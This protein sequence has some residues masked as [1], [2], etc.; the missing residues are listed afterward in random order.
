MTSAVIDEA[1]G[2]AD[3]IARKI[4][5]FFDTVND[6]L[7]WVP[8][9][10]DHLIDP[11]TES[12][13]LLRQKVE[14]FWARAEDF[15]TNRGD[16]EKLKQFADE[17]S[18]SIGNRIGEIAGDIE[19]HRLRTNVVWEGRAADAY[20]AI[21]PPQSE[22]LEGIKSL[23]NQISTSLKS[24]AN[25]IEDF[26]TAI[27]IAFGAFALAIAA[28]IV[29]AVTVVGIPAAIAAVIAAVIADFAL[30]T[31]AIVSRD[32]VAD[33]IKAEQD[34]IAQGT[35]DI[36]TEWAKSSTSMSDPGDWEMR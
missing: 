14:E 29:G 25:G 10:L 7:S 35:Q 32:A 15:V 11:I 18:E 34:S 4:Q 24:L 12:M 21:V 2:K 36:G 30:V 19:V 1:V 31:T 16:P 26:W 13:N 28:A 20:K 8:G 5:E 17:W 27:L 33:T 23:A 6:T 9:F 3:E 22:G